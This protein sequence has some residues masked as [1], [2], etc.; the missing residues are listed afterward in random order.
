M[1]L[2]SKLFNSSAPKPTYTP[3][4]EQEAWVAIMT[5]C[6]AIDG[7]VSD[8]EI[9][10]MASI[11]T[12]N[13]LFSGH[14]AVSYFKRTLMVQKEIGSQALIDCSYSFVGQK[15]KGTLFCF[16]MDLLLADGVLGSTE[17]EIAEYLVEKLGLPQDT[18]SKIIEVMLIK[19]G[20]SI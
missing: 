4:N 17:Q 18:A 20:A 9:G 15:S 12:S 8:D 1:G 10:Q 14:D 16:I 13:A 6:V 7:D 11:V 19:N 2:F 3:K 5:A